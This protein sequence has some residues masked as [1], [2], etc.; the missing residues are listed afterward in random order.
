MGILDKFLKKEKVQENKKQTEYT[1]PSIDGENEIFAYGISRQGQIRHRNQE[2]TDLIMARITKYRDGD[3]I[4]FDTSD[5][6]AFELPIGQE[7]TQEVM[8]AVMK[9][10]EEESKEENRRSYYIGRLEQ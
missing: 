8:Q 9:Q 10:Y 2:I 3:A 4:Y 7:V 1:M 5:Y 6:I